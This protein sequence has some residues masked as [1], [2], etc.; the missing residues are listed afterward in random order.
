MARPPVDRTKP[1]PY[2]PAPP[3]V[4]GTEP[5]QLTRAIWDELRRIADAIATK[6]DA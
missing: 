5:D 1:V 3:P 6:A 2:V 4:K